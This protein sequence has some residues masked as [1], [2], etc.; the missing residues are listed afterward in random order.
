[1]AKKK[2]ESVYNQLFSGKEVA[3]LLKI[4]FVILS[5]YNKEERIPFYRLGRSVYYKKGDIMQALEDHMKYKHWR[6]NTYC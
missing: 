4:S 6:F 2:K 5:K 1:M 3:D